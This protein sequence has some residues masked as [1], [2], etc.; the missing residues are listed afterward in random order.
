MADIEHLTIASSADM[1]AL[2]TDIEKG[3]SDLVPGRVKDFDASR[4]IERGRKLLA[5]RFSTAS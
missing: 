2:K 1:A 4:I 3:L 5:A